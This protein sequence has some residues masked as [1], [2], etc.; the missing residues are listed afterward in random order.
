MNIF[1]I[2]MLN[3][4]NVKMNQEIYSNIESIMNNSTIYFPSF[5]KIVSGLFN[6]SNFNR[7]KFF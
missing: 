2:L 1:E 5:K 4:N 3:A 6:S 7:K